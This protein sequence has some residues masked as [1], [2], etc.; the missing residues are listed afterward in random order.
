MKLIPILLTISLTI[1][2]ISISQAQVTWVGGGANWNDPNN[3][4][5]N[6]SLPS[7]GE[8]I[9]IDGLTATVDIASS[10]TPGQ[11]SII[12]G[13]QLIVNNTLDV[14]QDQTTTV[15]G[16]GSRLEINSGGLFTAE[17]V[18]ASTGAEIEVNGGELDVADKFAVNNSTITINGGLL[19]NNGL[20]SDSPSEEFELTNSTFNMT[21]GEM[22]FNS[23][24]IVTGGTFTTS[25]TS[26]LSVTNVNRDMEFHSATVNLSGSIDM[27][28]GADTDPD[29]W[30][31]ISIYGTST[32]NLLVGLDMQIDD[33]ILNDD[34][35]S[36]TVYV[37]GVLDAF[38]DL[39]FDQDDSSDIP[40]DNDRIVIQDGGSLNIQDNFRGASSLEGSSGIHV[41][42]GGSLT[43]DRIGSMT[44]EEAYGTVVTSDEGATVTLEGEAGLPVELIN[45]N[46]VEIENGIILNWSTAIEINND[47]FDVMRSSDGINFHPIGR[48]EGYGNTNEVK[49]YKFTDFNILPGTY[50]YQLKQV[51]FDGQYELHFIITIRYLQEQNLSMTISPNPILD[52][53]IFIQTDQIISNPT[54]FVYSIEGKQVIRKPLTSNK[55]WNIQTSELGLKKGTYIFKMQ[56]EISESVL[57]SVRV[58][59]LD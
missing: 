8:T 6:P 57:P 32:V 13:G 41:E 30:G 25:S 39:I 14:S 52:E 24:I 20:Q 1:L 4:S 21:G 36:S 23:N 45:F 3:W 2:T 42:S 31:D 16:S 18:T 19:D 58:S 49:T 7:F 15:S 40:G 12:N 33:L 44:P 53:D 27:H 38:D 54:L 37:S 59:I 43:I 47:Y 46:G 10:F 35:Q 48:V 26:T 9:I 29:L 55:Q 34:G 28:E 56:D 5:S 22:Q 11:I 50:F 17:F 51:D